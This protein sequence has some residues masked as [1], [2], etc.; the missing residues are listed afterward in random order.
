MGYVT[1]KTVKYATF[2]PMKHNGHIL[3]DTPRSTFVGSVKLQLFPF[4]V[5]MRFLFA[6]TS[7]E[8]HH[9]Y[10]QNGCA[11]ADKLSTCQCLP[12]TTI[13]HT[14]AHTTQRNDTPWRVQRIA[15][16]A[17]AQTTWIIR[18]TTTKNDTRAQE[19][20]RA[21]QVQSSSSNHQQRKKTAAKSDTR[22][23][24]KTESKQARTE[25]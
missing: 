16:A 7:R 15:A 18:E 11:T 17:Q 6:F 19:Q 10:H 12:Y 2:F 13:T 3:R 22:Y 21:A 25:S 14:P 23:T 5:R 20:Q 4:W 9:R 1:V 24:R 8:R